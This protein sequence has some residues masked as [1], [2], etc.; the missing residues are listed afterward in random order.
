MKKWIQAMFLIGFMTFFAF[1]VSGTPQQIKPALQ[2]QLE[3]SGILEIPSKFFNMEADFGSGMFI[4]NNENPY[5]LTNAHLGQSLEGKP[6]PIRIIKKKFPDGYVI[7][8]Y[9]PVVC[10]FKN[11]DIAI[12]QLQPGIPIKPERPISFCTIF[13]K[14]KLSIGEEVNYFGQP[15]FQ[16]V[17]FLYS[18][19][20][21]HL[22]VPMNPIFGKKFRG[23][24]M[25]TQAI[26]GNS[27]SGI[28]NG[29]GECVGILSSTIPNGNQTVFVTATSIREE[30]RRVG[31]EDLLNGTFT[32]NLKK[33]YQG[34]AKC[35]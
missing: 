16:C 17:P 21:S 33:E 29:K 20:I 3:S 34:I 31:I 23:A 1:L 13:S 19:K 30:F 22:S 10:D 28:F 5:F 32:G 9:A 14:E 18:G 27:G 15:G 12:V 11:L 24:A 26:G 2:T 7:E 35:H 4:N 8:T 25:N 6:Y